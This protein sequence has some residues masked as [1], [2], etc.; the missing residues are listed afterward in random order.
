MLVMRD[1]IRKF[2][3]I[4]EGRFADPRRTVYFTFIS[5]SII[6]TLLTI[7]IVPLMLTG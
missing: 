3:G 5:L 1:Y 4:R 6:G 7:M 2:R